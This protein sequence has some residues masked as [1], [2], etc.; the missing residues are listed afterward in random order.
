[1]RWRACAR[2]YAT[3]TA[4]ESTS[5]L[6]SAVGCTALSC[7][8][9]EPGAPRCTR[10]VAAPQ[11]ELICHV[12]CTLEVHA[13]HHST[14]PACDGA[15]PCPTLVAAPRPAPL[16]RLFMTP[17]VSAL[18]RATHPRAPRH[19]WQDMQWRRARRPCTAAR[20]FSLK[21]EPCRHLGSSSRTVSSLLASR[22]LSS[23][24]T[25][26]RLTA[27]GSAFN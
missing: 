15:A 27:E 5:L 25:P 26:L 9:K 24:V 18:I 14:P 17:L 21:L 23:G 2:R 20:L 7:S 16:P 13:Q 22:A 8:C 11:V 12:I 6:R 1:M 4:L 10:T 19:A 3:G